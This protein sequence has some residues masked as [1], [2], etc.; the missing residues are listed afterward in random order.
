M[1]EYDRANSGWRGVLETYLEEEA[2]IRRSSF[3]ELMFKGAFFGVFG[4]C[5]WLLLR[6]FF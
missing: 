2:S 1:S 6:G 3:R 5:I 4:F